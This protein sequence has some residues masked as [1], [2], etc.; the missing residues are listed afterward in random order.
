[1]QQ[2]SIVQPAPHAEV[3]WNNMA[4]LGRIEI[5]HRA[6]CQGSGDDIRLDHQMVETS[7]K[8]VV[9]I[10][11]DC[12][13]ASNAVVDFETAVSMATQDVCCSNADSRWQLFSR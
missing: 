1:M 11:A 2:T 5:S 3:Q 9:S 7:R 8:L 12:V 4:F 13:A 10:S 6:S